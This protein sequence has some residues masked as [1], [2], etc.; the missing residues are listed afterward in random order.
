MKQVWK[1]DHCSFTGE[2]PD[3]VAEHERG[4]AFNPANKKCWTCRHCFTDGAP[5]SGFHNGCRKGHNCEAVSD[6]LACPDWQ[7]EI[8]EQTD[9]AG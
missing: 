3:A 8:G 7:P 9:P 4:C 1:C 2:H 5:I 6:G